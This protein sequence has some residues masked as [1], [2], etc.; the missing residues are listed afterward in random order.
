MAA[1]GGLVDVARPRCIA[2]LLALYL[3]LFFGLFAWLLA[4][5]VR[6]FGVAGVWLA[7]WLWVA[8]RVAARVAVVGFPWVLLGSSQATVTAGGAAGERDR[9]VRPVGARRAGRH[10]R[11]GPRAAAAA[12]CIWRGAVAVGAAARRGR[13]L[14]HRGACAGRRSTERA[15]LI[16]VGLVQ[17]NVPQDAKWNPAFRDAILHRYIN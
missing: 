1:Y 9:R 13:G 7:P 15:R 14:R 4:R 6:R 12:R 2:G 10:G 5:A 8:S 17:G 16:R 11:G 3:A